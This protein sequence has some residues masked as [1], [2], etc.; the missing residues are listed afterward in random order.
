[1]IR[2]RPPSCAAT[3][4][5]EPEAV[6]EPPRRRKKRHRKDRPGRHMPPLGRR[7]LKGGS[8]WLVVLLFCE[9]CDVRHFL[10]GK[11]S[12]NPPK[13]VTPQPF[14]H[15]HSS[16]NQKENHHINQT[17]VYTMGL[18]GAKKLT[19]EDHERSITLAR[20]FSRMNEADLLRECQMQGVNE[21]KNRGRSFD[22]IPP[23]LWCHP[24]YVSFL[25]IEVPS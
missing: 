15:H 11:Q 18:F 25:L 21:N 20:R 6:G 3:Q 9:R 10:W 7:R 4:D 12:A 23:Y 17:K 2:Q 1:M 5:T 13:S 22:D 8:S 19:A 24:I 14:S 16:Q